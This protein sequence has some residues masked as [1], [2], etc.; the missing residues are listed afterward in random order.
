MEICS[1]I[2]AELFSRSDELGVTYVFEGET[3]VESCGWLHSF[4]TNV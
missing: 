3:E 2:I 1:E 4:G